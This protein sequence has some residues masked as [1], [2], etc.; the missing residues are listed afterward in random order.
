MIEFQMYIVIDIWINNFQ[1]IEQLGDVKY[2]QAVFLEDYVRFKQKN[3]Q[4]SCQL[5]LS[6]SKIVP[7]G[8]IVCCY[9]E[10]SCH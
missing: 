1:L 4:H 8:R 7:E 2:S 3:G 6:K 9:F 5:I 10:F